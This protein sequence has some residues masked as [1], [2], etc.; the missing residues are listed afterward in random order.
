MFNKNLI[1]AMLGYLLGTDVLSESCKEAMIQ[2]CRKQVEKG[3]D[4]LSY[5][6]FSN[7]L[8][9]DD[10]LALREKFFKAL[11]EGNVSTYHNHKEIAQTPLEEELTLEE[12]GLG[13][14]LG[15]FEIEINDE[16]V[17]I[18]DLTPSQFEMVLPYLD[19][20]FP[21]TAE[22]VEA[23]KPQEDPAPKRTRKKL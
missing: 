19:F 15:N 8:E 12:L 22:E 13:N 23:Q 20:Q 11:R 14:L 1:S 7:L 16:Q 6:H 21:L 10:Q 5:V 9:N 2:Q 3:V 4:V 17:Q 18:K